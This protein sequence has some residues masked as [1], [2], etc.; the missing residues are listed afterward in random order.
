[1]KIKKKLGEGM[2]GIVY[3]ATSPSSQDKYAIKRNIKDDD[4]SFMSSIREL[5]ILTNMKIHPNIIS[6]KK[7]SVG[8]DTFQRCM[9]PLQNRK[10]QDNDDI[11]FIFEKAEYD[12][13][14]L[15]HENK[16]QEYKDYKRY[17]MDMLLGLKFLHQNNI[18]HRDLKPANVLIVNDSDRKRA[19]LCDFG[20]AKQYTLQ[21]GQTPNTVTT[22]YRCPEILLGY[23][24]YGKECDI[25]S[26]GCIF[27]QMISKRPFVMSRSEKNEEEILLKKI[28]D[29]L[30]QDLPL[31][32]KKKLCET[33]D[34][35][36]PE[37]TKNHI[38]TKT[39]KN[40]PCW[41]KKFGFTDKHIKMLERLMG[42]LDLLC[43][44]IDNMIRFDWSKRYNVDQ[45]INHPFFNDLQYEN[46]GAF[47]LNFKD[48]SLSSVF[49]AKYC[50][51]RGWM[52]EIVIHDI[53]NQRGDKNWYNTRCLFHSIRIFDKYLIYSSSNKQTSKNAVKSSKKG[54][55]FTKQ[56]TILIY[57]VCLYIS[58]K[59]FTTLN[60]PT[61]FFEILPKDLKIKNVYLKSKAKAKEIEKDIVIN[62]FELSIY[63]PTLYEIADHYDVYIED[64]QVRDLIILITCNESL[65]GKTLGDIFSYYMKIAP[66]ISDNESLQILYENF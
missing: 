1:M 43:D 42:P 59:Y 50:S 51:E 5:D 7:I 63:E 44:L 34:K 8:D 3:E 36:I 23:E 60:E 10:D 16:T 65:V 18:V 56:E 27:Y 32:Y 4:V 9:S 30:P 13:H 37:K 66:Q 48:K 38:L 41:L 21:G 45:C 35:T 64:Q 17:M 49:N 39:I 33:F 54:L 57:Y 26:L 58:I 11:H 20:L 25:W 47:E 55:V 14:G 22:W 61:S 19:K 12:L 15:I 6:L 29:S 2:Y 40:R 52:A 24:N 31:G 46:I 28:F 62:C 53:F